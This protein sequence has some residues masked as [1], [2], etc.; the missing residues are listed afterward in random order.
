MVR[1]FILTI[2]AFASCDSIRAQTFWSVHSAT[3]EP[4]AGTLESLG[5]GFAVK[6]KQPP[7]N[8]AAGELISLRQINLAR[9]SRPNAPQLILAN[10]DCWAG[11][12]AA[13]RGLAIDWNWQ[14]DERSA[15]KIAAPLPSV[16]AIWFAKPPNPDD[17]P[18]NYDWV[19][20]TKKQD[21]IKLRNG[22][23]LKGT[24]ESF[25]EDGKSL[26]FRVTGD[27]AAKPLEASNIAAIVFDASL[28]RMKTPKTAYA[29]LVVRNGS[30]LSLAKASCDGKNFQ[31]TLT[32]GGEI[33]IPISEVVSLDIVQGKAIYLSDLA[34]KA[35]VVEPFSAVTWNWRSDRNVKGMPLRILTANG[36]ETFDRGLGTHPKTTLTYELA[37]KYRYF[38]AAV[39]LDARTGKKGQAD[40]R[41]LVD[42][43]EQSP[44]ELKNL[45]YG[46]AMAVRL[47]LAKVKELKLIVD[48]GTGG[49]VQDDVNWG[50]ARLIE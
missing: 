29:K 21:T 42:G 18:A 6:L 39:G 50:D 36:E 15:I 37:G 8:I 27:A 22:D 4:Q 26:R 19:D 49:D 10:G 11:T 5:D 14:S 32:T 34:P 2:F 45:K 30:R 35:A 17:D 47:S 46:R 40:V 48:F 41:V 38:E 13:S 12:L 20:A 16:R 7:A 1:L 43:V 31:T 33:A 23:V 3:G 24:L 25:A 44:P 28:T 9:P